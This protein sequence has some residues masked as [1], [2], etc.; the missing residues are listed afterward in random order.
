MSFNDRE[1]AWDVVAPGAVEAL[2]RLR[3]AALPPR[4][5]VELQRAGA[6][7]SPA[8]R[9][10]AACRPRHRLA[11]GGRREARPAHLRDRPR[12]L[13]GRPRPPRFTAATSTTSTSSAPGR[14]ACPPC[15]STPPAS[16]AMPTARA[17]RRCRSSPTACW[18]ARS[19]EGQRTHETTLAPDRP[20]RHPH[21]GRRRARADARAG[22]PRPPACC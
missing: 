15:C 19:I 1:G 18:R 22:A 11:R 8:D 20:R 2:T 14:R 5:R 21:R 17:W 7:H 12:A 6:A 9:P 10:R 13:A 16:T 4:G 3:A